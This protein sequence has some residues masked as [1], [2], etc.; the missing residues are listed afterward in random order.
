MRFSVVA[1]INAHDSVTRIPQFGCRRQQIG[2]TGAPFPTMNNYGDASH[3]VRLGRRMMTEQT[4]ATAAIDYFVT[5]RGN[6]TAC[7]RTDELPP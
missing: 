3:P 2:R 1:E 5:G 7:G 4:Y 6:Q